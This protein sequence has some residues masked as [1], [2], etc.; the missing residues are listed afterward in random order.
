MLVGEVHDIKKHLATTKHQ[1][2][3]KI[4]SSNQSLKTL[5]RQSPIE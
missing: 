3:V 4:T 5:F 1:E 2:M